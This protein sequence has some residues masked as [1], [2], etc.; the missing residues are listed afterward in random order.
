MQ[1]LLAAALSLNL[2]TTVPSFFG[3]R[4]QGTNYT[5]SRTDPETVLPVRFNTF[6]KSAFFNVSDWAHVSVVHDPDVHRSHRIPLR[7]VDL[8]YRN[9][10]TRARL[11]VSA[12]S[13]S[14]GVKD[15]G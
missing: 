3:R 14:I 12:L 4:V 7:S 6:K 11:F 8:M 10:T 5:L 9:L 13:A 2:W 15:R 1:Q